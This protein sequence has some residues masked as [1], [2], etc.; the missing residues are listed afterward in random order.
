MN[1]LDNLWA[2]LGFRASPYDTK[3]LKVVKS[4]VELLMG[5]EHEQIDFLNA[6]D[7][8]NQGVFIISGVPGV[9][10]TSFLNVQQYLLE[11]S[12]ADFGPKIL[13]ARTLCAIQPSDEPEIIARRCLQ[14]YCSSIEEFCTIQQISIP[15]YVSKIIQWI[16]QNKPATINIGFS[17]FGHGISVGREVHLPSINE[18]TFETFVEIIKCLSIIVNEELKFSGSFIV[19]DNFENLHEEDLKDCLTTFRDTLFDIS[20]IWWIIIGQSGLSSFIQS[21]NP[22][23]FQ[24]FSASLELKPI[25]VENLIKAVEKRVKKF[26]ESKSKASSPISK[27]IYI[28]LFESSNGEIRFVFKYCNS[29]CIKLVQSVRKNLLDKKL[30]FDDKNFEKLMG[31][32]LIDKQIEDS[33]S[34]FC[35]KEIIT[36][37]FEGHSL[38]QNEKLVLKKIGELTKIKSKDF[39]HF[40]ELGVTSMQKFTNNYLTKLSDQHLLLRRQ[41]AKIITYE[42]RGI[43]VFANE[44][45]LLE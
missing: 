6:V 21:T 40:R 17:V 36:N 18:T 33:F 28:K 44:Y 22:K 38:S 4:D 30:K 26:H 25:S 8:D 10:K 9:G 20:N 2:K 31:E 24:R 37:E 42:L 39:E 3:P 43:S 19:M 23:V 34:H 5:R 29:I 13:A 12:E 16:H 45:D 35:L 7:S 15:A 41:E 14:S 11:S 32:H 1:Q 27:E